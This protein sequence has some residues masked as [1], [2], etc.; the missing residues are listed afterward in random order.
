MICVCFF[1]QPKLLKV[2][3]LHLLDDIKVWKELLP[4][5]VANWEHTF[6]LCGS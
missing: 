3:H 6:C 4:K 1:M 2:Q 5:Q